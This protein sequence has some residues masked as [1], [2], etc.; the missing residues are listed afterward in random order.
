MDQVIEKLMR[1]ETKA[2]AVMADAKQ[3]KQELDKSV[4]ENVIKM[5]AEFEKKVQEKINMVCKVET[6]AAD[7][8]IEHIRSVIMAERERMHT[9]YNENSERFAN[10]IFG[11]IVK[12]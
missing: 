9:K 2:Q 4:D 6:D 12:S 7:K 8:K 11:S 10:E 1:I 3:M 5:K